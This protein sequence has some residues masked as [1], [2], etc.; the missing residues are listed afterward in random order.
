MHTKFYKI[1]HYPF[2]ISHEMHIKFYKINHYPFTISHEIYMCIYIYIKFQNIQTN[3][4]NDS[5]KFHQFHQVHKISP[6]FQHTTW[7]SPWITGPFFI[8]TWAEP[9]RLD[10]LGPQPE[11]RSLSW[12]D[13]SRK[14]LTWESSKGKHTAINMINGKHMLHC[15]FP[16]LGVPKSSISRSDFP[17]ET[18]IDFGVLSL[19]ETPI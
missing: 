14:C 4:S 8:T 6:L 2:T 19:M 15:S 5:I 7:V 13:G 1:N 3:Q 11:I 17:W 18:T 10:D 12:H 16:A 9:Q